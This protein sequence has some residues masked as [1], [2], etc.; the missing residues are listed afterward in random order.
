MTRTVRTLTLLGL[1][2]ALALFLSAVASAH[3]AAA[4]GKKSPQSAKVA[5]VKLIVR[6]DE[7]HAKKGSDGKWHDAF[8]PASFAVR[9]GMT[10]KVTVYNYDDMPHSFNAP[11]LHLNQIIL[12]GGEK[13]ASKTTFT[14]KATKAGKFAWHCDPS[15]DPWAMKHVGFMKGFVTVRA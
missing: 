10:V 6:S 9:K 3:P 8:L 5:H 14:F 4:T 15:C 11:G 7:E 13:K 12:A 2:A 1:V